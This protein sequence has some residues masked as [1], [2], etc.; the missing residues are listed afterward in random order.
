MDPFVHQPLFCSAHRP[1]HS[2]SN[3]TIAHAHEGIIL[4]IRTH[5]HSHAHAHAHARQ[6]TQTTH[7]STFHTHTLRPTCSRIHNSHCPYHSFL[8][9]RLCESPSTSPPKTP[10]ASP[11]TSKL[12]L[13]QS[14]TG[15]AL[16]AQNT[17]TNNHT[18][19]LP[20]LPLSFIIP[21]VAACGLGTLRAKSTRQGSL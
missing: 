9:A 19:N 8:F 6:Q 21:R 17:S 13:K 3:Q 11:V 2:L 7:V 15:R 1:D 20:L 14:R 4:N 10:P 5:A 16:M 18:Y 12:T